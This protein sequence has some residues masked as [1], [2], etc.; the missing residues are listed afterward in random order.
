MLAVAGW[1]VAGDGVTVA[2]YS[3]VERCFKTTTV[4][5]VLNDRPIGHKKY[6]LSSQVVFGG[7]RFSCIEM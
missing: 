4:E 6:G 5:P 1:P 2:L 7:E 3:T